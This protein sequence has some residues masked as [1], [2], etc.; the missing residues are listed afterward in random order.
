MPD[1]TTPTNAD[2]GTAPSRT[3]TPYTAAPSSTRATGDALRAR[4]PGRGAD[5]D[6]QDRP[7]VPRLQPLSGDRDLHALPTQQPEGD[8]PRE[9][10]IEHAR[11]T[12]VF[13]TAAPLHGL[14]GAIRRYSYARYSEGRAAHWLLLLGADR[15]DA[16]ES[17]LRSFATA[18][19]DNPI[20]Q[21]GILSE[22][23]HGPISSRLGRHRA[24]AGH[25]LLDPVIVGGP[26]LAAGAV[27]FSVVR[28]VRRRLAR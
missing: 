15:V 4:I 22:L 11:L 16:I 25:H 10:S 1:T 3:A 28:R 24:D 5:L 27:A 18:R 17:H 14:S 21:T 8:L 23:S 9:R 7:S 13:G 26:W 19:P 2:R 6:P 20:T 12:P